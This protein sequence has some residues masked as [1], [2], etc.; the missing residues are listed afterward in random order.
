[1][2]DNRSPRVELPVEEKAPP[3]AGLTDRDEGAVAGERHGNSAASEACLSVRPPGLARPLCVRHGL[4]GRGREADCRG[5]RGEA[6][7]S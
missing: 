1:M 4:S 3:A 2:W 6:R 5:R 7:P